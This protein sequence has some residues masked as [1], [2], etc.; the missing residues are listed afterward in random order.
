M[1]GIC[2]CNH[3]EE[4]VRVNYGREYKVFLIFLVN[5]CRNGVTMIHGEMRGI[6]KFRFQISVSVTGPFVI[7]RPAGKLGPRNRE[8]PSLQEVSAQPRLHSVTSIEF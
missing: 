5:L 3:T 4:R 8:I 6:G 1:S 7:R 2:N